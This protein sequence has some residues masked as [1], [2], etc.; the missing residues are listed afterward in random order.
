[1]FTVVAVI[2]FHGEQ[3][4]GTLNLLPRQAGVLWLSE[5]S[6]TELEPKGIAV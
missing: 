4:N 6:V 2:G 5:L 1:M 3:T